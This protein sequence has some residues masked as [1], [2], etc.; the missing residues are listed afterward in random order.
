V[1]R[2]GADL[3]RPVAVIAPVG[4]VPLFFLVLAE[5]VV[6]DSLALEAQWY[7]DRP[8]RHEVTFRDRLV[9]GVGVGGHAV[10]QVEQ[11]VGVPVDLIAWSRGE[12]DHQGVEVVENGAVLLVDRAVRLVHDHQVEVPDAEPALWPAGPARRSR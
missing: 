5:V 8:G 1:H 10:L 3:V 6:A 4:G 9:K 11:A 7:G 12:P 2:I